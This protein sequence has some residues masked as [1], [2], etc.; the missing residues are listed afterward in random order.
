LERQENTLKNNYADTVIATEFF[1]HI[2]N[3]EKVLLEINRVLKKNGILYFTVPFIWPL[4]ETPYDQYRYTPY[5]LSRHFKNSGFTKI[6]IL[7]L[8]GYNAT[9]AQILCIWLYNRQINPKYRLIHQIFYAIIKKLIQKDESLN[10]NILIDGSIPIGFY[11]YI[12]K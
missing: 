2:S 8:G 6:K 11:G 3:I 4:H 9:L 1:E 5:S 12:Q 10:T 7:P